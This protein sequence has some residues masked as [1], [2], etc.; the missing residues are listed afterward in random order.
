MDVPGL[1][2]AFADENSVQAT[3]RWIS[4]FSPLMTIVGRE[5]G[6]E[7]NSLM[8]RISPPVDRFGLLSLPTLDFLRF[9]PRGLLIVT[10][11]QYTMSVRMLPVVF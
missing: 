10:F 1:H 3:A 2:V 11:V 6:L 7:E 5:F 9:F 4:I 8:H